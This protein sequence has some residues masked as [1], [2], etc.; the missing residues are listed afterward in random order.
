M[1]NA[2][3]CGSNWQYNSVTHAGQKGISWLVGLNNIRLL[4]KD[5]GQ[6]HTGERYDIPRR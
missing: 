3:V 6:L 1:G 4:V 5:V 2:A